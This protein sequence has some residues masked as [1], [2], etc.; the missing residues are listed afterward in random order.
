MARMNTTERQI[1]TNAAQQ[2]G[3]EPA[4][5]LALVQVESGG[6][7]S[8]AVNGQREPLIRFEGHYFDRALS[9]AARERA[10]KAGLASPIAGRIANPRAQAARW[11]LLDRAI[12]IN[13][14]AALQSVSWGVGQVMG[15]HWR[16]LGYSDIDAFVATARSGLEGQLDI[17]LGFIER[18]GLSDLLARRDW[19]GFA[20]RY[21]GP[22]YRRNRY[23]TKLAAAHAHFLDRPPPIPKPVEPST[24]IADLQHALT[25]SGFPVAA[26]GI[27]DDATRAAVRAFQRHAGITSDAIA[28]PL[29]WKHLRQRTNPDDR[30]SPGWLLR[31]LV[32]LVRWTSRR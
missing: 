32:Q 4:A 5:L 30:F 10:R 28:G 13:R 11:T 8:V 3:L 23:D 29:T 1:I 31:F 6:Q 19:A 26:S 27:M 20:R 22:G 25:A 18:N 24:E 7:T 16:A 9:G 17:M 15:A 12:A 2:A 14:P 21:N